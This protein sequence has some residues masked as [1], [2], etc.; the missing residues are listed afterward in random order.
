M[1]YEIHYTQTGLEHLRRLAARDWATIMDAVDDQLRHQPDLPTRHRKQM[2]PNPVAP[3]ELRV[4][5]YRV[6]YDIEPITEEASEPRVVVLA[7]GLKTGSRFLIG[8][9][10]HQL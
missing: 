8:D 9:E 10:E 6:F 2:R 5:D 4:G 7:I 3:W 1:V